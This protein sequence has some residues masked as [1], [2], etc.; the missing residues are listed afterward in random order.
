[1]KPE[2]KTAKTATII[3]PA[4]AASYL[5]NGDKES[6]TLFEAA[7]VDHWMKREGIDHDDFVDVSDPWFTWNFGM[8]FP[9]GG[10]V[11]GEVATYTFFDMINVERD[12][13]N[14]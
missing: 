9:E 13:D 7:Q 2:Q 8:Y 3:G 6:L 4:F 1:M 12:V 5:I 11:G 10:V 14:G